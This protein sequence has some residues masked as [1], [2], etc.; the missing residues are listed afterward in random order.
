MIIDAKFPPLKI[1]TIDNDNDIFQNLKSWPLFYLFVY[2]KCGGIA[3]IFIHW[4]TSAPK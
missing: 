1:K 4:Q 2:I 3:Q